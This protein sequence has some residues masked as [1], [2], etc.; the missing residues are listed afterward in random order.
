V[1]V[2][3][4]DNGAPV[5]VLHPRV[6]LRVSQTFPPRLGCVDLLRGIVMVLM[7]LDHSRS[8]FSS[9]HFAPEDVANTSGTLFFTRWLTHFC[10]PVFFLLAGTGP[11]LSLS[12][13]RSVQQISRLFWTRGLWIVFLALT[14]VSYAW[15][16]IFPFWFSDVLW[17]LGWSMVAM[18][19]LIRLPVSA[20]ATVGVVIV[21]THNLLDR[22]T[23]AAFGT[24]APF[25]VILHGHGWFWIKPGKLGF[26]VLFA[27]IPWI[28]VMA[29]GYALGF[30]LQ[31]A[32][33]RKLIFSIGAILT[34][35]FA[36][37]RVFHLYGNSQSS[38]LPWAE[39][40]AGPWRVQPTLIL[41]IVSF[42]NTVKHPA[43]L[44]FLLM[45]LGPALMALPWLDRIK[46]DRGPARILLVFGRAPLFFYVLHLFLIHSMAVWTALVLHQ[47]AAWLLY[48]GPLLQAPPLGYGHGLPFIY[49]MWATALALLYPVCKW[50]MNFRQQHPEYWW[51]TSP[52]N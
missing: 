7:A 45:T 2:M 15:T 5:V 19:L 3:F 20:V 26:F 23:P 12:Q 32:N 16:Y 44:Q 28:G 21:L 17:S 8:F 14:V 18:A 1:Q 51:L 36:L 22:M 31:R 47:P 41:T 38:L 43:S 46:P 6:Q 13:G 39:G 4:G 30:L 24:L 33:W 11:S 52:V 50:F 27:L 9:L 25:W 49:A 48:G 29:V 34:L 40:I 42:F 37:L 10:A 35:A